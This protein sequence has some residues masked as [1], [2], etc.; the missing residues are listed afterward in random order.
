MLLDAS[1]RGMR[2]CGTGPST[3]GGGVG[4]GPPILWQLADGKTTRPKAVMHERNSP[5]A[6][7]A[8]S[9]AWSRFC[10]SCLSACSLRCQACFSGPAP[11]PSK[12]LFRLSQIH[13]STCFS[14]RT[15]KPKQNATESHGKGK[16]P[17]QNRRSPTTRRTT[18]GGE[19]QR[20]NRDPR[21][22]ILRSASEEQ[23]GCAL[24]Q[25]GSQSAATSV[26]IVP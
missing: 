19:A 8:L 11:K 25:V 26:G 6:A 3:L 9:S 16:L 1:A 4:Q 5:L 7:A 23:R 12:P 14:E 17:K 13:R 15:K 24:P 22:F 2:E 10:F 21:S 18:L 20:K